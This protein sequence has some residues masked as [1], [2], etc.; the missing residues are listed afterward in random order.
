MEIKIYVANLEKYN[1][2]ELVG[3]WFTLPADIEEIEEAIGI[4]EEY[5]EYAIH[6]YEAPE[7]LKIGEYDS[8]EELNEI[9]EKIDSLDTYE[10]EQLELLLAT[11]ELDFAEAIEK[12]DS[13]DFIIYHDCKDMEDVAYQY[14]EETGMLSDVPEDLRNYFDYE[15]FGRDMEI[16]G[17]FYYLGN[18]TYIQ[19]F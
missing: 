6:D 18:N 11:E 9:A 12:L 19:L 7:G 15:K 8:I 3:G 16:E 13:G 1:E 17:N 10:E 14:I 2:G 5:E 4:N